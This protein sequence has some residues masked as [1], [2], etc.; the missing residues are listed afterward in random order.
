MTKR[1]QQKKTH[2][3]KLDQKTSPEGEPR[4]WLSHPKTRF[5]LHG[6]SCF[7]FFYIFFVFCV[8]GRPLEKSSLTCMGAQFWRTRSAILRFFSFLKTQRKRAGWVFGPA[9]L[10]DPPTRPQDASKPRFLTHLCAIWFDLSSMTHFQKK[11]AMFLLIG[12]RSGMHFF[13]KTLEHWK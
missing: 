1:Q 8:F 13:N 3:H 9:G 10:Q 2:T 12:V 6:S 4:T 7:V 5:Y 11:I